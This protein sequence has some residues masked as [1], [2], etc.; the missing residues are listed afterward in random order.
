MPTLDQTPERYLR[1]PRL[2]AAA[3][4][5]ALMHVIAW[6]GDEEFVLRFKLDAEGQVEGE[7]VA[8]DHGPAIMGW[9]PGGPRP[10]DDP[11]DELRA[12]DQGWRVR[13]VHEDGESMVFATPPSGREF[14][15]WRAT[16]I[17]AAPAVAPAPGGAWVAF[18]HDVRE[19]TGVADIA[20]WIALRFVDMEG[21]VF[22]PTAEMTG[23]DRDLAGEEQGFEFPTLVVGR[24]GALD[25]F[26]RGSHN[27]YRQRLDAEGFGERQ[28]IDDGAWGCRGRR[29]SVV[30]L[31][32]GRTLAARR[33]RK[34]IVIECFDGPEGGAPA[35]TPSEIDQSPSSQDGVH[36]AAWSGPQVLFGDIQQHSAHSDGVGSADETYLR[37]RYRYQDDFA[38]LTDHESFLG[39]RIGPGEWAYLQAV[40]ERHDDPGD[41]A[42]LVAYEWT[43]KAF[44]GP[45]HKCVYLPGPGYPIVSRDDVPVGRDLVARVRAQGA[46]TGPHHIGWTGADAPGHEPEGQPIWEICSC[47]GCY[48]EPGNALGY[49]GELDD[50]FAKPM[51]D[52]GLRFGF[53]AN[54]DSHGLLWHHGEC[55]K[56]DPFRTGLTAVLATARTREAILDAIRSRRCYATSGAKILLDVQADGRP[57]GSEI[58]EAGRSEIHVRAVGTTDIAR[59][60]LVTPDGVVA[61]E[62]PGTPSVTFV[63]E[64]EA[65]YV[66]CRVTQADRE[67]AWSSPIFFGPARAA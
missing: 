8:T 65:D 64:V 58:S 40:A 42:T 2:E 9:A 36:A 7:P 3:G 23:R 26:G 14:A 50:Q 31:A 47:H 45:G 35:M 62:E 17:A 61:S 21:Q 29:T 43:G 30:R 22:E 38:A 63:R 12:A 51:L 20:K 49:R 13:I 11:T 44:P 6:S 54:S 24:D 15:V 59:I 19:D 25:V 57:M 56:R 34:G 37:A 48:E 67:M 53:I 27:V 10:T 16:G 33:G 60:E 32:N 46:M 5:G 52:S 55:R 28:P 18:H 1:S 39:K 41:F 66:Y 4:G